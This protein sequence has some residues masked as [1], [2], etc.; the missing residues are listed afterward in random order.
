[1]AE[2][3]P[4]KSSS[5][6]FERGSE[7]TGQEEENPE[8]QFAPGELAPYWASPYPEAELTD[9][10]EAE[11]K[12]L[13]DLVGNKDVA[14]RR[15]EV[16]QSWKARLYDRGYQNLLPRR[17]GGWV[18]P[19]FAT[20]YQGQGGAQGGQ[21]YAGQATN[22]Y[23][24]Y[25]EIITA[26][27]TRDVPHVRFF[28]FCPDSDSDVTAADAAN[29][30]GRIF[31]RSNDL[32]G[33]LQQL[34]YYL[35]ND[36][37]AV[38]VTD[39]VLDAQRFGHYDAQGEAPVVPET[40]TPQEPAALYIVRHGA[41]PL[42]DQNKLRGKT[43]V[44]ITDKGSEQTEQA[45]RF[46]KDKA[47]QLVVSSTT[48]RAVESAQNVSHET[49][50]PLETDE[51]FDA[52]DTGDM[53]GQDAER[54]RD[55]IKQH[56]EDDEEFPGGELPSAFASRVED[57]LMDLLRRP[58]SPKVLVTHDS[59]IM[60][61]GKILG[62]SD[63][64]VGTLEPGWIGAVKDN[65]DGTF[66][67]S[68]VYP[69]HPPEA[70]EGEP[71][72]EVRGEEI[73]AVYGKL[74]AKVPI[75]AEK[76][77]DFPF[78]QVSKEY[79]YAYVRG[80]FPDQ[81][82]EIK[83]GGAGAGENELDRIAR[84]NACLGLESAYVTGDSMVRDCTVQRVW[85]RP[86]FFM[87]VKD[88]SVR[89]SLLA[90]FP[91]GC[92]VVIAGAAFIFARQSSMDAHCTLI[93]AYPGSGQNRIS[94]MDKVI[95][96]Q[97]YINKWVPLMSAYFT[98]CVAMRYYP[99][100]IIDVEAFDQQSNNPGNGV[101]YDANQLASFPGMKLSDLIHV[102]QVPQN[103]PAMPEFI[104]AWINEVGQLLSGA[105]PT[106]YGADSN[107]DTNT[108]TGVTVQ[109]D[110]A[111]AR[112]STPWHNMSWGMCNVFR[113]AVEL[114]AQCRKQDIVAPGGETESLRIELA[115]LRGKVLC[116]PEQDANFPESWNQK[117]GR[118]Q[119]MV[120]DA[121]ANPMI[122][123]L[124]TNPANSR[125]SRQM[126]GFSEFKNPASDAY[127]KQMGEFELLTRSAPEP[128]PAKQQAMM[129]AKQA[130]A[131]HIAANTPVTDPAVGQAM[132][133]MKQAEALPDL[134][135]SVQVDK[136][137]D[138]HPVEA[139]ACLDWINS[140]EGRRYKAGTSRERI[141]FQNVRLHYLEH[142][143]LIA[144]PEP[145]QKPPSLTANVKDMPAEIQAQALQKRYGLDATPE[146][147]QQSKQAEIQAEAAKAAMSRVV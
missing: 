62:G 40:E 72:G 79:D 16:E 57:G 66:G 107:T 109:R 115:D 99:N 128:N 58:E 37:R 70:G 54:G 104:T 24:T 129:V 44:S 106:L 96:V 14:A 80:M 97:D 71:Q 50:V 68:T 103:Q 21:R 92:E 11:L 28:P 122:A 33:L 126:A 130:I 13:C 95:S 17:G 81:A 114:A 43:A 4:S 30:Y 12:S 86:S 59:V 119:L 118:F 29:R 73:A 39:H 41:T 53:A 94:I 51:R 3:E 31:G 23:T 120:M 63:E 91:K 8:M 38:I 56:F 127:E 98:R 42:N 84:I 105:L 90:K 64:A 140:A 69:A 108:A 133:Q 60:Q 10:E 5:T 110:Q 143:A 22:I 65:G 141:G 125:L 67:M 85:F 77:S 36:G 26:A 15:W 27:L 100:S 49:S 123:Q 112:L 132:Q 116:Y 1:M 136:D 32:L 138:L 146:Q 47:P 82:D 139:Q 76:L 134:V 89:A 78:L 9:E 87:E 124:L 83:P 6:Y 117:Q 61:I 102:E 93:Q 137:T 101:P 88:E 2:S 113:Q 142:K 145:Q 34:V 74:E 144:P 7:P 35:R 45:G 111:L 18:V 131:P 75:N 121:N 147:I 135:S 19:P 48:P 25:G 46:L 52:L 20:S 55:V